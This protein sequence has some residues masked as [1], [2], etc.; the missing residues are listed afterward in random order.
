MAAFDPR[1]DFKKIP[2]RNGKW[3][4]LNAERGGRPEERVRAIRYGPWG[5]TRLEA[6]I[7]LLAEMGLDNMAAGDILGISEHTIH[8]H[9]VV[10]RRKR[11]L[12]RKQRPFDM[13][14]L[15]PPA[16]NEE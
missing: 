16:K 5:L 13:L 14:F 15:P 3:D 11:G 2:Q 4:K 7:A 8:N 9:H 6:K 10:I 1:N 12:T